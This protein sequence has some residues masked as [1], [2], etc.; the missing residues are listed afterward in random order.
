MGCDFDTLIVSNTF[1]TK[2]ISAHSIDITEIGC[3]HAQGT[4]NIKQ[5]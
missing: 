2:K 5:H 3:V 4:L 1:R